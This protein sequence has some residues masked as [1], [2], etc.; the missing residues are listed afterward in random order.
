MGVL[1]SQNIDKRQWEFR[2]IKDV[3]KVNPKAVA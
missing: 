2:A 3:F 1:D